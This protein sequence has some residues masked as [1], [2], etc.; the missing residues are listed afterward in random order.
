MSTRRLFMVFASI[1]LAFMV[2]APVTAHDDPTHHPDDDFPA[3]AS[4]DHHRVR[5]VLVEHAIHITNLDQGE[6]G[7]SVGDVILWGPDPMFDETNTTDTGATTQGV[8]TAFE[9]GGDCIL[10]ETLVFANG[11]TLHLQ[12]IQ[13]GTPQTSTRAIIGGTGDYLGAMGIVT[14][15]PTADLTVWTK[16]FDILFED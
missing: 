15:E 11:S 3:H 6:T 1:A 9:P 5:M 10:V 14:V 4:D 8:C 12:G 13:P 2:A 7:P 16:T